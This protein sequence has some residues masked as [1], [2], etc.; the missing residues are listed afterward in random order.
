MTM[1]AKSQFRE[2]TVSDWDKKI[3]IRG[4][5]RTPPLPGDV[6]RGQR[7]PYFH[8]TVVKDGRIALAVADQADDSTTWELEGEADGLTEEDEVQVFGLAVQFIVVDHGAAFETFA[9]SQELKVTKEKPK[10]AAE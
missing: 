10:P 1:V 6:V 9:W 5:T 3:M 7:F 8:V 2:I 4:T